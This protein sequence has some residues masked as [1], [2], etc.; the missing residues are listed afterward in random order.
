MVKVHVR[1]NDMTGNL[2]Y[3]K[4]IFFLYSVKPKRR[5]SLGKKH[6]RF[7]A[8]NYFR[9]DIKINHQE[10]LSI[11]WLGS[12]TIGAYFVMDLSSSYPD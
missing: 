9:Y 7:L 1:R 3:H 6:Q 2:I 4:S 5:T 8:T 10:F 12:L 11:H